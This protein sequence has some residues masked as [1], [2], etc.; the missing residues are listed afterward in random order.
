MPHLK[1]P[2]IPGY[3]VPVEDIDRLRLVVNS[4][5]ASSQILVTLQVMDF[6][7]KIKV[8]QEVVEVTGDRSQ[9][10]FNF[11]LS[12]G[13]LLNVLITSATSSNW[14]GEVYCSALLLRGLTL[15][16]ITYMQL[17][18]G[19]VTENSGITWPPGTFQQPFSGPGSIVCIGITAP[20]PGGELTFTVPSNTR[21]E[22]VSLQ[23]T[24]TADATAANR[25]VHL[26]ITCDDDV[27]FAHGE[28][29]DI[30]ATAVAT[31]T[32]GAGQGYSLARSLFRQHGLPT[33]LV[34][35]EGFIIRT[36]TKNIQSTD[37]YTNSELLA[38]RWIGEIGD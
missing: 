17:C 4:N 7:G 18:C 27:V 32:W 37:Q 30:T 19:Y 29:A 16:N 38:R 14:P 12:K 28:L 1:F 11:Q 8:W 33:K 9:E 13:Y 36:D 31:L 20:D 25:Q 26:E 15:V 34:I 3:A 10:V 35:E 6:E 2:Q 22:V 5:L 23:T 24:F 21:L